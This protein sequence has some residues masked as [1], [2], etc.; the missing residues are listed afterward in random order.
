MPSP[1]DQ[2]WPFAVGFGLLAAVFAVWGVAGGRGKFL[3]AA[4]VCVLL[5]AG[6][7]GVDAVVET[8]AE[9]LEAT[10]ADLAAAVVAGDAE[11]AV[12]F[13]T[14]DALL[15]RAAVRAGLNLVDVADDVR[16]TDWVTAVDGDAAACHF[17]ANA[18]FTLLGKGFQSRHPTRWETRW[19]RVGDD[20]RIAGVTRLHPITG[21]TM[22]VL[23]RE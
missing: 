16:L 5:A 21:E 19:R 12:G 4:G 11:V 7:F 10:V 17:R 20:W 22:G 9:R 1:A 3:I 8:E 2:P 18:T 13:F 14:A 15:A 6:A 23:D